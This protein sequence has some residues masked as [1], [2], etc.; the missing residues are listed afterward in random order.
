MI[1]SPAPVMYRSNSGTQNSYLME[2]AHRAG[3]WAQ[4]CVLRPSRN[5]SK[6]RVTHLLSA[7]AAGYE[8]PPKDSGAW[9]AVRSISN[10]SQRPPL[11]P[12]TSACDGHSRIVL[13]WVRVA[14]AQ[15]E[16][17]DLLKRLVHDRADLCGTAV[18]P[19]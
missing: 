6:Q 9:A 18:H 7:S 1:V 14:L 13:Q 11:T 12:S 15:D 17:V 4:Q 10:E 3:A 8:C 19:V 5:Q 16:D 2:S